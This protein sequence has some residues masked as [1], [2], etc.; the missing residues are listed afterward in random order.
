METIIL[1][2]EAFPYGKNEAFLESEIIYLS[3][4][5]KKIYIIPNTPSGEL[6][7]LPA[8]CEVVSSEVQF[9]PEE[10]MRHYI[11]ANIIKLFKYYI[12][13][14]CVSRDRLYYIKNFFLVLSEL[15]MALE[16]SKIYFSLFKKYL[17][18]TSILYFYWYRRPF[19]NFAILKAEKKVNHK[20]ISR[21]HGWDY[22]PQQNPLGF[23]P[24]R[25][26]EL[27]QT[28]KLVVTCSWGADL[29]KKLFPQYASRIS[30]SY[31]GVHD[32]Q[33]INPTNATN[34][35]HLV[36]CSTV[37]EIKRV[38][39][40]IEILKNIDFDLTWTHI[41]DGPM[42]NEI[43]SKS[44]V[45]PSKVI[46]EFLGHKNNS[47][48]LDYYKNN[49][50]DLFINVSRNEGL[51]VSMMEAISYGIPV[52]GT[53]VG[54]VSELVNEK[55]GFLIEKEFDPKEV[56]LMISHYCSKPLEEKNQLRKSA[57]EYFLLHFNAEM[58]YNNFI[59]DY[60]LT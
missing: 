28:D 29:E 55:T 46:C 31:L 24:Y 59:N 19:L 54:G 5:F 14:V 38:D 9:H 42:L 25:E 40:I 21:A 57:R 33:M 39:L 11:L 60:L 8:N 15:A 50:C 51:P 20:L 52:M 18:E 53:N 56:A 12:S 41:G 2:T 6:R 48:I 13:L 7:L 49:P 35:F 43:K 30:F 26:I 37:W 1:F 23:Y 58:N 10:K 45:L 27:K 44:L 47:D 36:S 22:D 3:K 16:E 17:S 4:R 34:C 32:G